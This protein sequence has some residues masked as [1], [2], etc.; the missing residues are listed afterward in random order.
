MGLALAAALVSGSSLVAQRNVFVPLPDDKENAPQ[1][2]SGAQLRTGTSSG[3][4]SD[5]RIEN[6]LA[7]HQFSR[8][9]EPVWANFRR[10]QAQIYRGILA[11]R[12]ND[13]KKSIALLEPVVDEV[14][15]SGDVTLEK[16]VRKALAE[17]YM[18][19]GDWTAAARAYQ[20]LATRL[21]GKLSRDEQ[22]E[23]EMPLAM[24]PLAVNN[25]PMTVD[26]CDPFEIQVSRN[27]LGLTDLPV[28][29]DAHPHSWLLDP[30]APFN[31]ISRSQAKEAGLRISDET[32]TIH[33]LTG[34][35][36]QVHTTVIPRFTISGQLTFHDMTAFVFDD[37]DYFF[38]QT[39]YQVQGVLGYAALQ[40]LGSLTITDNDTIFIRP[41]TQISPPESDDKPTGG[42]RFFLDGD[43]V[44]LA[45]GASG[46]TDAES[47]DRMYVVD[48]AGQQ[49][50][51]TSRYFAE[52][53]NE[54]GGQS[55]QMFA[56][57]GQVSIPA[58]P[59]YTAERVPLAVG[60][61]STDIHYMTVLTQPLGS[62][63]RDDVYGVLGVDALEQVGSYT[64]DYRTMQF[65]IH[66]H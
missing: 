1:V 57:R 50:F 3:L 27:L 44:I 36:M 23:I 26:P 18:R 51:L 61:V 55:P 32:A 25:P 64:F 15:A 22:D 42:V 66:P 19:E 34:R 17:D 4:D 5:T 24:L 30:T 31:L 14:S 10:Q 56:L 38:P 62:T 12:D 8:V 47:A 58:V 40:A 49:T 20:A 63:A 33:T 35:P 7:D 9:Q 13:V 11:N 43:L 60:K 41:R 59:A 37:A 6:L 29:V 48:A 53:S 65:Q 45:L 21:D 16:L 2:G 52:H 46:N 54:F 39:K 28:F